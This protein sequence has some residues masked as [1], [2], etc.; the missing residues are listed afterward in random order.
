MR[1]LF[2]DIETLPDQREGALDVVLQDI[3]PPAQYK[4]PESIEKWMK[5]NAEAQAVEQWKKT[6]LKGIA[7]EVCSIA[8]AFDDGVIKAATRDEQKSEAWVLSRFFSDLSD[9]IRPGEGRYP[10]LRWIG[11]NIIGFDLRFLFQ[12]MVINELMPPVKIPIN[13]RHGSRHVFD[14]M[15]EWAGWKEWAKLDDIYYALGI[16]TE[17][18]YDD[19]IEVDGSMV[20]DLWQAHRFGLIEDYNCYDVE[21]VRQVYKRLTWEL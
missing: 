2:F 16:E 15:V 5:E 18:G 17:E 12:R 20:W 3:H 7:G 11:H 10:N 14:T 9:E 13:D 21:K 4:K 1:N 19:V 8:W 6:A